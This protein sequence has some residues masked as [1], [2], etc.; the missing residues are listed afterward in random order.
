[1]VTIAGPAC[2]SNMYFVQGANNKS[3]QINPTYADL[4]T[5]H[6]ITQWPKTTFETKFNINASQN[7]DDQ[8]IKTLH[9]P[10]HIH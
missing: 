6:C 5:N 10:L 7:L 9:M 8:S 4:A 3:N 2:N 1:M